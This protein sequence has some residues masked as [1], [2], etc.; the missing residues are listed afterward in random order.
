MTNKDIFD[1]VKH[2]IIIIEKKIYNHEIFTENSDSCI[3]LDYANDIRI[4]TQEYLNLQRSFR[5]L[6]MK[7][8]VEDL[9]FF[10]NRQGN[11][12]RIYEKI[13]HMSNYYIG[14][15]N[16]YNIHYKKM[17]DAFNNII[18][19]YKEHSYIIKRVGISI[20]NDLLIKD[21]ENIRYIAIKDKSFIGDNIIIDVHGK[22]QYCYNKDF[23]SSMQFIKCKLD[24]DLE[25]NFEIHYYDDSSVKY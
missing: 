4:L 23:S 2:D 9:S 6:N 19:V 12:D 22:T 25:S 11:V 10:M 8:N 20:V 24:S 17:M 16:L 15:S 21:I 13:K 5:N 14:D 1:K 18:A 3:N 7:L